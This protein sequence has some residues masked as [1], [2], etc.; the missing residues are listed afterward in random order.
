MILHGAGRG[1]C[2]EQLEPRV[3]TRRSVTGPNENCCVMN[4]LIVDFY[5]QGVGDLGVT[6]LHG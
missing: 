3:L 6:L 1:G 4:E 5:W 2:C